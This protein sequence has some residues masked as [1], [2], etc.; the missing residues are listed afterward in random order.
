MKD[1]PFE[2]GTLIGKQ[3]LWATMSKNN[4]VEKGGGDGRG[5]TI[6]YG[7]SLTPTWELFGHDYN[8]S[9]AHD[10]HREW[11]HQVPTD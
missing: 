1:L 10:G 5:H 8:V 2:S 6:W 7:L 3:L 4:I 11:N 9:V